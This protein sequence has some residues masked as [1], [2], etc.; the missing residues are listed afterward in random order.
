MTVEL[1]AT[2][3]TAALV[4]YMAAAVCYVAYMVKENKSVG[5]AAVYI[6]IAGWL[7]HTA[8]IAVRAIV[9][10]TP[11]LLNMYE[12]V[13]ALIWC[14][15]VIYLILEWVTKT[16][17]FGAF[18]VPLIAV[19]SVLLIEFLSAEARPVMPALRSAWR[20]PH[21]V[22]GSLAY[23][24]FGIAFCLAIMY[25]I[26][27]RAGRNEQSFW[28]KRLPALRTLDYTIYRT[29]AFGFLLQTSL[30]LTGALWAQKSWARYWGWDSKE[31]W[32]LIT[33]LV[34]AAYLHTRSIGWK[35]RRSAILAI[36]GF[37]VAMFT[38]FGVSYLL[39]G[40]HSY[41]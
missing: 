8:S 11:P 18:V 40:L 23:A 22:S 12:Y 35:G 7:I 14:A 32:S 39:A 21:I 29:V 3:F 28:A 15:A 34:Y 9:T 16:K 6:L 41:A 38:L 13:L 24:G 33:W 37:A 10:K 26:G 27:E 2:L 19:S 4:F 5:R 36:I 17:V 31:T 1:G 30:I 25:L 20:V